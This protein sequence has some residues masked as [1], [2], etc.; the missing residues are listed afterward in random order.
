MICV[1]FVSKLFVWLKHDMNETGGFLKACCCCTWGLR[2]FVFRKNI[3]FFT[4]KTKTG[5]NEGDGLCYAAALWELFAVS[6]KSDTDRKSVSLQGKYIYFRMFMLFPAWFSSDVFLL[7]LNHQNGS[8]PR[9]TGLYVKA[10][11]QTTSINKV[12]FIALAASVLDGFILADR[13]TGPNL[14]QFDSREGGSL[15]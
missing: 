1:P 3:I 5:P 2:V 8:W 15:Q 7:V 4:K 6:C 12:I 10:T 14:V 9:T 13:V 11:V